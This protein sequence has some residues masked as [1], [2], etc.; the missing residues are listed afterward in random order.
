MLVLAGDSV[1]MQA[2]PSE[3][4]VS[5]RRAWL[6]FAVDFDINPYLCEVILPEPP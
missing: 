3:G 5:R 1:F 6:N 2:L 4:L